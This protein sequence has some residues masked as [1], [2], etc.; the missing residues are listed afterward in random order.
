MRQYNV[1]K[2]SRL[3]FLVLLDQSKPIHRGDARHL[4]EVLGAHIRSV[5]RDIKQLPK[6]L[7]KLSGYLDAYHK[8]P[9]QESGYSVTDAIQ[10]VGL[11]EYRLRY[12]AKNNS[13]GRKIDGQW[14]FTDADIEALKHRPHARHRS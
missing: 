14:R 4:A 2:A 6:V 12:L 7:A 1:L 5:Q 10:L 8:D 11:R 13:I 9:P 3:A